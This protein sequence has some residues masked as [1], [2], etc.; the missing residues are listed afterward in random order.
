VSEER[1][2]RGICGSEE[3]VFLSHYYRKRG[4]WVVQARGEERCIQ[5]FG[6]KGWRKETAWKT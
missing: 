2:G 4:G 3:R 1:V 5:D 6:W